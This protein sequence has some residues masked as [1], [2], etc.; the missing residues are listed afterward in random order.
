[1]NISEWNQSE[2]EKTEILDLAM[3][4]FGKCEIANPNYFDWQ[5]KQNPEGDTVIITVKDPDKNNIIIGVNAFLPMNFILNQ[6]QVKCFLSCNS[7][8]HPDYR[9]KGIF[10]QLISKIPE[11]FSTKQFSSIYGIPNL[12]SSKI[13]SKNQFLEV[14]KLPLLI[15][16]LN[17]SSYFKPPLS[18]IIKPFDIFWKPKHSMESDIQILDKQFTSEF[19]DIIKKSLN[20]F[21]IFHFKNK[22]FLQWRYMNHPTRNYQVL[23]LRNNSKLI[24]Y[25]ISREMNI[26]SKKLGIIVDF[27]IDPNYEQRKIFQKLIKSTL[28]NFW[29]NNVSIAIATSKIGTLE[30]EILRKSGFMTAPSFLKQEQL[31]LIIST[32]NNN[33]KYFQNFDDW[34]FALG[35][36]DVF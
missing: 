8:V 17:L 11:I 2:D 22:E 34:Y 36:Y 15:K 31:P 24:G 18:K 20:R 12:N 26:F 3:K 13:F 23:T 35:D 29:N 10:T 19:D 14:S 16:P 4:A 21:P 25:I 1:M 28:I 33:F 27:V 30:N 9:K 5:Y 6:K 32:F 7:I